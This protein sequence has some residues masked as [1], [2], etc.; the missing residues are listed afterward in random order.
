MIRPVGRYRC[1]RRSVRISWRTAAN[2]GHTLDPRQIHLWLRLQRGRTVRSF[3]VHVPIW[4][5]SP[6]PIQPTA[7]PFFPKVRC[8]RNS[9]TMGQSPQLHQYVER[10]CHTTGCISCRIVPAIADPR[11]SHPTVAQTRGH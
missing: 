3:M 10:C 2:D 4:M 7:T 11:R 5:L 1:V 8:G 6:V 9:E